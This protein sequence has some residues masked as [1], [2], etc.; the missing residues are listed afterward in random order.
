[1]RGWADRI[2]K[3]DFTRPAS[4]V[5]AGVH[6]KALYNDYIY[7]W[8]WSL[9]R[10]FEQQDCGG[11][12]T[13][14][15]ASS[16]LA[17]HGFVGVR[18]VM[19]RTF[20]D[21]WIIDLG[22]DN[23]GTRKTP[24]VFNIQTPVA[25]AIGARTSEPQ[26]DT[27][28]TVKYT[29][30]EAE[31][32]KDK[33]GQLDSCSRFD[34]FTW[35]E[36][37]N[38]W[39]AA[40]LPAGTGA[41]FEWPELGLLFPW[42]HSG[43]QFTRP[44]PIGETLE[45]LEKRFHCL[46]SS[47]TSQRRI[48]F[49]ESRDRKITWCPSDKSLPVVYDLTPESPMPKL[50]RYAY[51]S[52][53][54]HYAIIDPRIGDFLRP[55]LLAASMGM[56]IFFTTLVTYSLGMGPAAVVTHHMPDYHSFRGSF[57][58]QNVMPLY[59]DAEATS[60]NITG[61]LLEMLGAAYGFTP[62]P[63]EL[64]AYVYAMLGGQSYTRR[65]WNELETPGPRVPLTRDGDIF[66]AAAKLGGRL[67]WLHTYAE[68]FNDGPGDDERGSEVPQ[69]SATTI[70][71]VSS[72]PARYPETFN[73]D[74]TTRE[75][76]VGDGRFGPVTAEIWKFEV[77]GLMVVQS[78]LGYRMKVRRGKKS[79]PLDDIRP[80]RWTPAMSDQ[81]LE[82]LWVLEATLAM[83]PELEAMLDRAVTGPCFNASELPAPSEAERK[84]PNPD[85]ETLQPDLL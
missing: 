20:D 65:F 62:S 12:I 34:E 2:T 56:N 80:E 70:H 49:K 57:G 37:P 27:P 9:W 72:D 53:D 61:G 35:S 36:C 38:D 19:R 68:R 64:A 43:A 33:L 42:V 44:W 15:T 48:L 50:E 79:S 82:L 46:K 58:G 40:F 28:A 75:I 4:D 1:M 84:P 69:G 32:R 39:H 18:E 14:I 55:P 63:E 22:G 31:S 67:I 26:P 6:L 66:A 30:V 81:F 76:S 5:G 60:P 3:Q 7:F 77:S 25:I 51:R 17:G 78:W 24:N 11:V 21:I 73:Y 13:F 8:R 83:E 29:R 71:G 52:F 59:R 47:E 45:V 23:L 10:L 74:K 41:F 85:K 16:Y 54:C